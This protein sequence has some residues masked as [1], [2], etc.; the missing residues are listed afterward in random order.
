MTSITIDINKIF[1]LLNI[2]IMYL[3]LIPLFQ[4]VPIPELVVVTLESLFLE[5]S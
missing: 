5:V 4:A 3:V 2:N 1:C